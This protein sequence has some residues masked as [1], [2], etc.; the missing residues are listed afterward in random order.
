MKK[1]R[2]LVFRLILAS[3]IFTKG[4]LIIIDG[5]EEKDYIEVEV[6]PG[7]SLWSIAAEWT[8]YSEYDT[9]A[10]VKW[11]MEHN[12]KWDT[13]VQSGDVILIPIEEEPIQI[14]SK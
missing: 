14:A 9:N 11:M 5:L 7:D 12:Q 10:M 6:Q 3:L 1:L 13:V 4:L 8:P 2:K